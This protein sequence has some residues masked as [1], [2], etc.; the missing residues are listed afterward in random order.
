RRRGYR[1]AVVPIQWL[2]RRG[3]RMQ[4]TAGLATRVAWDLFRIPLIHRRVSR[5]R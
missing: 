3:S 5:R 4:A 1:L 2:D